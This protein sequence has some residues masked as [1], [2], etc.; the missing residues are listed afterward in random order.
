MRLSV[1]IL[2]SIFIFSGCYVTKQTSRIGA[3]SI[4]GTEKQIGDEVIT[5]DVLSEPSLNNPEALLQF[6]SKQ[7]Y[8]VDQKIKYSKNQKRRGI[9]GFWAYVG[10]P[11]SLAGIYINSEND[12]SISTVTS[13]VGLALAFASIFTK[14]QRTKYFYKQG[15][16]KIYYDNPQPLLSET[17]KISNKNTVK[18]FLTNDKGNLKFSPLNDFQISSSNSDNSILF[19]LYHKNISLDDLNLKPS[20][21]LSEYA[22]IDVNE[23]YIYNMNNLNSEIIGL[24][25]KSKKYLVNDKVNNFINIDL[26]QNNNGWV[27]S[28]DCELIY[29]CPSNVQE[30]VSLP[31]ISIITPSLNRGFKVVYSKNSFNI[32]GQVFDDSKIKSVYVNANM[33]NFQTNGFFN[34][35]VEL[36]G[37]KNNFE[38]RSTDASNNVA[39]KQ[40]YIENSTNLQAVTTTNASV[41]LKAAKFHALIIGVEDYNDINITDLDQPV[42]DAQKFYNILLSDYTFDAQNIKF[43]K[44]PTKEQITESLEYYFDNITEEDNLLIFYAGHGYW[45]ERFEQGY[46]LASDAKRN[47]RG[48]WLSNSTIRDYMRAIPSQ[49]SLLI[50]DACFGGGIFKSRNAFANASVAIN[51]LYELPS[52][53]ALTSGALSEVPDKS[54]FI[55]YMV[56]RLSQ[57]KEKYLS[58]EQ[59][60]ASFKIAVINNSANSQVP[61]FGEVKET[62]DEG[63]DFIF[64]HK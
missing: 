27:T 17:I 61:Q 3:E 5:F 50:T 35:K 48:T 52:R 23:S 41:D 15:E 31:K 44:N 25:L 49:H 26:S 4:K 47:N 14:S 8:Q 16:P 51:K 36:Y 57:N 12:N 59:L 19:K 13:S 7:K 28:D 9:A 64:I 53:K 43:L 34:K 29:L 62:G 56:K 20:S 21:W 18:P 40:F 11:I 63:G 45:D 22:R 32:Q 46:W 38:V 6:S 33:V 60:F 39:I 24:A 1:V 54:V 30:D 2:I 42:S 55:E 58:S 10:I 37:G